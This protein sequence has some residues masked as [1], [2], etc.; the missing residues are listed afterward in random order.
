MMF[1]GVFLKK[2]SMPKYWAI[3]GLIIILTAN[4]LEFFGYKLFNIYS[5]NM[6]QFDNFGLHFNTVAFFH[7]ELI[8]IS[9]GR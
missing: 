5:A 1:G 8:K 4:I 2:I 6:L 7:I 9:A 3:A